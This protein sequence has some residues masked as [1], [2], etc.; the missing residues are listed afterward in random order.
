MTATVGSISNT[1]DA[2]TAQQD[3]TQRR[4]RRQRQAFCGFENRPAYMYV[5]RTQMILLTP[6]YG[7]LGVG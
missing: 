6:V 5:M 4:S 1:S 7:D 3:C 2:G